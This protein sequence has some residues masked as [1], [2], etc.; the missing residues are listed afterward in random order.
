MLWMALK[1]FFFPQI[2]GFLELTNQ[3]KILFFKKVV[4]NK[5]SLTKSG[6]KVL[7]ITFSPSKLLRQ[8]KKKRQVKSKLCMVTYCSIELI[9][10]IFP[11]KHTINIQM[12]DRAS[13]K[14][15]KIKSSSSTLRGIQ[16]EFW[17]HTNL[18]EKQLLKIHI[19]TVY[20][21]LHFFP[22]WKPNSIQKKLF[23]PLIQIIF[24]NLVQLSQPMHILQL[25]GT[26]VRICVHIQFII[27]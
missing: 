20:F 8:K 11:W 23:L 5:F 9:I 4:Q 7:S 15:L 27:K 19:T 3:T 18:L 26:D 14:I 16:A 22:T 13:E 24:L 6:F 21:S 10:I 25:E 17:V 12:L 2:Q 1:H